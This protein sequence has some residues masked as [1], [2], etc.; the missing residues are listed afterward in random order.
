MQP[1]ILKQSS[2]SEARRVYEGE[3]FS[4][5]RR[6]SAASAA[7]RPLLALAL[8]SR[9]CLACGQLWYDVSNFESVRCKYAVPREPVREDQ[10]RAF[11]E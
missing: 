11:D 8:S 2:S 5:S 1:T 6:N 7:R 9:L 3:S 4:L 10:R